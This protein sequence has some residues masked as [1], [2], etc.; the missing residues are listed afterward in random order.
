VVSVDRLVKT[1]RDFWH[2]PKVRAVDGL[3]LDVRRGEIFGLLG[4]NGSGKTTT[5]KVLLGLLHPTSGRVRVLGRS[6]RHVRTKSRIGY[7]PEESYLYPYLTPRETLRFYAKLFPMPADERDRRVE[8]LLDMV[9]LAGA[10]NRPVGE[11]SKGM[12]RRVGL[13]QALVNNPDLLILDEPTS[14]LDPIGCRQVKDLLLALSRRGKTIIL[15]SHL[16]ADMED[17]CDRIGI[18]YAGQLRA[19]GAVNDLLATPDRMQFTI[20]TLSSR[21]MEKLLTVLRRKLGAEPEFSHPSMD[22]EQFFLRV[23]QEATGADGRGPEGMSQP[24]LAE[25]L[26]HD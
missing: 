8:Q 21:E 18:L 1:F 19:L 15:T 6:P 13:A 26:S 11:F 10:A 20:P 7:L 17:V 14:G 9:D 22:L 23:V 12:A 16:L 3:C 24:P 5:I 2:R 25:Y 4:P